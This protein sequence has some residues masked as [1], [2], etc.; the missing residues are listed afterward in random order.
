MRK[1]EAQNVVQFI[2]VQKAIFAFF[3][4]YLWCVQNMFLSLLI[5]AVQKT[6]RFVY[7]CVHVTE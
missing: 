7:V 1:M 2:F 5:V 3:P 4:F 6:N